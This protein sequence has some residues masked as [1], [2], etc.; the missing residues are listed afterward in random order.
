MADRRTSLLLGRVGMLVFIYYNQRQMQ[1]R[2]G[3]VAT[4]QD[5][6]EFVTWLDTLPPL[7]L[8]VPMANA[9]GTALAPISI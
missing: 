2:Q 7:V 3:G 9:V 8:D 6:D 5:W 1:Q 4:G